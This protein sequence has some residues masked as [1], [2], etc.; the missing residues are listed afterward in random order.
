MKQII[1]NIFFDIVF[2]Y[3]NFIHWNFSKIIIYIYSWLLSLVFVLPIIILYLLVSSI[4]WESFLLF[5]SWLTSWNFV[6]GLGLIFQ[7]FT[8]IIFSYLF[9]IA[10]NFFLT[11]LYINYIKGNKLEYKKNKY[12]D[13]KNFFNYLL[14][15][16]LFCIILLLPTIVLLIVLSI[17]LISFW[18]VDQVL[19]MVS[20]WPINTFSILALLFFII[21]ILITFYLF[22]RFVFWFV[23]ILEWQK[24][25]WVIDSL[26]Y[27]FNKTKGFFK[28]SKVVFV[29]LLFWLIYMPFNY[30]SLSTT[31]TYNEIN[32]YIVYKN[33]SEEEQLSIKATNNYYYE[34][35]NINYW[36][37][38]NDQ[39]EVLQ[40]RYYY[41][42]YIY[43]IIEF[44]LIQ[45]FMIMMITSIYFRII[46]E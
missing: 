31:W 4:N 7:F 34:T 20:S 28:L 25:A 16:L 13:Y 22:Y 35:L 32:N 41:I 39:L 23:Y 10:N 27:S 3:K 40:N 33:S 15:S 11:N 45:W 9:V 12:F 8:I 43:Q 36:W 46:K 30:I 37:F 42:S 1:K 2:L 21:D 18:W 38:S 19:L 24:G 14:Y 6:P 26:K 5:L 17:V 44:L 29:F